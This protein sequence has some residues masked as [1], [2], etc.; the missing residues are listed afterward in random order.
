MISVGVVVLLW[1]NGS[2]HWKLLWWNAWITVG[3]DKTAAVIHISRKLHRRVM[4]PLMSSWVC[5]STCLCPHA[6]THTCI[7]CDCAMS[8]IQLHAWTC[9]FL[10]MLSVCKCECLSQPPCLSKPANSAW[11]RTAPAHASKRV[12]SSII[13]STP[14]MEFIQALRP[15]IRTTQKRGNVQGL[16]PAF[17]LK[18]CVFPAVLSSFYPQIISRHMNNVSPVISTGHVN[19]LKKKGPDHKSMT[20]FSTFFH[21]Y[22]HVYFSCLYL[23]I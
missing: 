4:L 8:C 3:F 5:L 22:F 18:R 12:Q 20:A 15:T 9:V 10:P 11:P 17:L 14:R 23:F 2:Q 19:I 7:Y 1:W 21:D 16:P 6:H 13:T